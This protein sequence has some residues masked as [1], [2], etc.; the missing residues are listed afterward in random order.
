MIVDLLEDHYRAE[1]NAL[2]GKP[3]N[4]FRA[5]SA[6]Y[7]ER[8]LGYELLGVAGDPI[9]PRRAAVFRHG[10]LIDKALKADLALVLGDKF[11]NLDLLPVNECYIEGVRV[12]FTPDGA[13]QLD[14]GDIGIVEI[15][16]MNGFA[17]ER[18]LR[19]EIERSYLAQAWVYS[20]GTG[21]NPL[22][23]L[24]YRKEASHFCE[25]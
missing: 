18:A 9:Q 23:F 13:W 4:V 17:F 25:I 7:C 14:N 15:K 22:V 12:T 20:F 11:L 8:R 6:G 19:G 24:A 5:S 10:H 2:N 3:R 1:A 21:F 16:S